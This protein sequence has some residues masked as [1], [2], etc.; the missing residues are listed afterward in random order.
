V[1]ILGLQVTQYFTDEVYEMLDLAVALR[2]PLFNY[3]CHA[4]HNACSECVTLQDFVGLE[5]HEGW[6]V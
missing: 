1:E 3:N 4:N 2:F 5:G 6:W